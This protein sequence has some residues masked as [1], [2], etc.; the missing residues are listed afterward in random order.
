VLA[1]A[2]VMAVVSVVVAVVVNM[3]ASSCLEFV[4][5]CVACSSIEVVYLELGCMLTCNLD[6]G[7]AYE[8]GTQKQKQDLNKQLEVAHGLVKMQSIPIPQKWL[9]KLNEV[10]P[11]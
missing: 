10:A 2:L 5:N 9:D 8:K 7:Q 4:F 1:L 11:Q 6:C 3:L